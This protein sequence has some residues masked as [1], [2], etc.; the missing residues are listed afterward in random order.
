[1]ITYEAQPRE[2]LGLTTD[3]WTDLKQFI[4]GIQ[5]IIRADT[6]TE[7]IESGPPRFLNTESD[8]Q[9]RFSPGGWVGR[10]PGGIT[11]LPRPEKLN[12]FEYRYLLSELAGR[13][14]IWDVPTATSVLPVLQTESLERRRTLLG[15]SDALITFTEGVIAH[16]PPVSVDRQLHT[17]PQ[18]QGT[19]DISRTIQHRATGS[20]TLASNKLQFSFEHPLNLMLVR[21]H[22]ELERELGNLI[23]ESVMV[24]S[25]LRK[26]QAYHRQFVTS[27]F[28][29]ALIDTALDTDF[30]DPELRN[31]AQHDSAQQFGELMDIW[32]S[33]CNQQALSISL[34]QELNIG[35]KPVEKLYELWGLT[36]LIDSLK[37]I[38]G[39]DATPDEDLHQFTL[40]SEIRLYYNQPLTEYSQLLVPGFGTH[41]GRPDYAL[42][43][44][45]EIVW[46][47]DAKFS[48]RNSIR[49]ED[50]QR[51]LS[52]TMDL[53]PADSS[54]E[55]SLLYVSDSTTP[56]FESTA[57]Y[58]IGQ[59]PLRP[60]TLDQQQYAI[61]QQLRRCLDAADTELK[62]ENS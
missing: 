24:D 56:H 10:Y 45:D 1:M 38:L 2:E 54:G 9:T 39:T 29:G 61:T 26:N 51:F 14:E 6:R 32:E 7:S 49:L 37:S 53:V 36:V 34:E 62:G 5:S 47:G 27:Q 33:F 11:V 50:Y 44:G 40:T 55:A 46:V 41:P 15:Y 42:S 28:S 16:R 30:R 19:I 43:V 23:E 48:P 17:G 13:L 22:I 20:N 31:D 4:D 25:L 12:E 59:L 35:L 60:K 18:P 21:F 8:E 58:T 3:E 52:Y 57:A